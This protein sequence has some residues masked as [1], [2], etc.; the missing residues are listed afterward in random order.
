M[1]L[2]STTYKAAGYSSNPKYSTPAYGPGISYTPANRS[3]TSKTTTPKKNVVGSVLG[4][5]TKAVTNT[6]TIKSSPS[7]SYKNSLTDLYSKQKQEMENQKKERERQANKIGES[8]NPV[9]SELDRQLGSIPT[10]QTEYQSRI[11]ES[12][13]AQLGDVEA[14]RVQSTQSLESEK[15][16]GLRNLEEDIRNQMDAAGTKIGIAGAGS[17][18]AAGQASEALARVGQKAR[19]SLLEGVNEQ[20]TSINN[21]ATEQR[22]KIGQWKQD[23]LGEIVSYFQN[24]M[25]ELSYQKAN[26]QKERK[27]A[28]EE[29]ISNAQNEFVSALS[30]LDNQ[31]MS[32]AQ[33]VDMWEKQRAAELD[34]YNKRTGNAAA[35][36]S[37]ITDSALAMFDEL[38]MR[39]GSEDEARNILAA[40]GIVIPDGIRANEAQDDLASWYGITPSAMFASPTESPANPFQENSL[41]PYEDIFAGGY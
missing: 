25:D 10:R 4:S 32:Y 35:Q 37:K 19:G 22:S 16:K 14:S 5:N 38:T 11:G 2:Q 8:W 28:V 36:G 20:L 30:N 31:V 6:Q 39:T 26:A 34:D 3:T 12:A 13:E 15:A 29:L 23:K 41:A 33:S 40:Q 21:L 27:Q 24:K 7:S 9:F 18:S 17:S 1:A